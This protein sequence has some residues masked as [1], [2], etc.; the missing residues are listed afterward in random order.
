[1]KE[2]SHFLI[3]SKKSVFSC[4]IWEKTLEY[5]TTILVVFTKFRI[6]S[7]F[8]ALSVFLIATTRIPLAKLPLK[9][10]FDY[11][12]EICWVKSSS[13]EIWQTCR[14]LYERNTC[15]YY[16]IPSVFLEIKK[17]IKQFLLKFKKHIL[18]SV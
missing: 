11:F 12:P 2:F 18:L 16:N 5:L 13:L 17:K 6:V 3:K 14:V 4:K 1:M 8:S 7:V 9:W 10:I 15:C